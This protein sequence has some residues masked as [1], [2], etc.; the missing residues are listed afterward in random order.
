M[1]RYWDK[2]KVY[3]YLVVALGDLEFINW[4]E[5]SDENKTSIHCAISQLQNAL[6]FMGE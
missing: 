6:Y 3:T 1:E 2:E 4:E 5:L